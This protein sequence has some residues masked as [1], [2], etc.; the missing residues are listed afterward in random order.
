M[1]LHAERFEE[2][3]ED[4]DEVLND[5]TITIVISTS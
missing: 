4:P 3:E 1:N 2:E 5:G